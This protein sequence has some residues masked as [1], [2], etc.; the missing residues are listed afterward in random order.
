MKFPPLTEMEPLPP[1]PSCEKDLELEEHD[2][3]NQKKC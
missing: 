1:V 3:D 2:L